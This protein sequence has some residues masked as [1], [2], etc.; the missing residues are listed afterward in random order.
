[1]NERIKS[2]LDLSLEQ[3]IH[4]YD[5]LNS[6]YNTGEVNNDS[7]LHSN[8]IANSEENDYVLYSLQQTHEVDTRFPALK[9]ILKSRSDAGN[10]PDYKQVIHHDVEFQDQMQHMKTKWNIKVF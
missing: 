5:C 1:M 7:L 6:R 3:L 8:Y 4:L 9:A 10:A 2:T